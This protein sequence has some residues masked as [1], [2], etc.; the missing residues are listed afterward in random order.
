MTPEPAP[1]SAPTPVRSAVAC[2]D[3]L[4]EGPLWDETSATLWWIDIKAQV[5]NRLDTT[6]GKADRW[7]LPAAPGCLALPDASLGLAGPL[8]ALPT[9][10]SVFDPDS[11]AL[12][13]F[14]DGGPTV[15]ARN[16]CNDGRVDAQGRLWVGT[17]DDAEEQRSGALY[18]VTATRWHR[19]FGDVGV[20]NAACFSLDGSTMYWAD[21]WDR[22][23]WAFA[24]DPE[25]AG[26][27]D[28]RVF[29]KIEGQGA[30]DGATVDADDHVWCCV[31]DGWCIVRFR[32]DGTVER[33]V[34]LPVQRPTC[35]AFGGPD[36][37]TLYVTSAMHGLS[38]H[39]RR[40]QP[41][42]GN[43]LSLDAGAAFG[44]HGVPEPRFGAPHP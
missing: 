22:T 11:L 25:T 6:T 41:L 36:L 37:A 10:L 16:R 39:D 13:S 5:L 14:G 27:T 29:A 4:G 18:C 40:A 17:M 26:I 32:P 21:S 43:V 31:W 23:I 1:S 24:V 28:R 19:Q 3:Q 20:P 44:V 33:S 30:P 12:T 34:A 7:T 38:V 9:G 42:A 35:P 15:D 2:G 8:V